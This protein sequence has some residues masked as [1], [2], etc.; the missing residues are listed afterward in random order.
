MGEMNKQAILSS[1]PDEHCSIQT[2]VV[3]EGIG[4]RGMGE[5]FTQATQSSTDE[6]CSIQTRVIREGI[7]GWEVGEMDT[8]ATLTEQ[9]G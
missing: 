4:G 1:T 3:G 7:S 5:I 9:Y 8:Q 2:R 6:H